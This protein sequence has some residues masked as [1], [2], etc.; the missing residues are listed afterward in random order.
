MW[1]FFQSWF[2]PTAHFCYSLT[3]WLCCGWLFQLFQTFVSNFKLCSGLRGKHF[4]FCFCFCFCFL[5]FFVFF[6]FPYFT[7]TIVSEDWT[8]RKRNDRL[9]LRQQWLGK[10]RSSGSG[11]GS[12][13]S[14]KKPTHI[15]K[16]PALR[17]S[18][19]LLSHSLTTLNTSYTTFSA[20]MEN[21]PFFFSF[22]PFLMF[23][24]IFYLWVILKFSQYLLWCRYP[25][26]IVT[27][28]MRKWQAVL[29]F[30][31]QVTA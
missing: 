4:G 8:Y 13:S 18:A 5:Y 14:S 16:R 19:I 3:A 7:A 30:Q 22:P 24:F 2:V 20:I 10:V 15:R 21:D 1:A 6:I 12:P 31:E 26:S 25:W 29:P 11:S 9:R 28:T 27:N 17:S 23:I